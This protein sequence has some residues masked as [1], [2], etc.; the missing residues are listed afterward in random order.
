M[1][2]RMVSAAESPVHENWKNAIVNG[3][4]TDTVFL[5]RFSRPALR[6]LR[7]QRTTRLE[8]EDNVSMAEF[9]TVKDLY[10][11]GD[12]EA[13]IAL[14]GQVMGR[15]EKVEPVATILSR[16]MQE[17]SDTVE[18]LHLRYPRG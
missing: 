1:G 3:A 17:F 18:G 10:F 4:E 8:H 7:T 13:S 11:G 6:A 15:I 9:G 14:G 2:T 12:L 5:N 16:T